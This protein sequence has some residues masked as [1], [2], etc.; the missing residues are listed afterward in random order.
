MIAKILPA[1][2]NGRCQWQRFV[3]TWPVTLEN[4][5]ILVPTTKPTLGS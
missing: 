2:D 3:R 1:Q 4:A 5:S